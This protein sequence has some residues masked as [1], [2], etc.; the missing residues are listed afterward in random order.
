MSKK[1]SAETQVKTL[2]A[3]VNRMKEALRAATASETRYFNALQETQ[4]RLV[5]CESERLKLLDAMCAHMKRDTATPSAQPALSSARVRNSSNANYYAWRTIEK[6]IQ[7]IKSLRDANP[8]PNH[9]GY[10]TLGLAEAK[11]LVEN[12]WGWLNDAEKKA[13]DPF[14]EFVS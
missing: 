13:L 10:S 9:V 5:A 12:G 1:P 11:T 8:D 3:E 6:K 4:K 7:A 14:A 2:K